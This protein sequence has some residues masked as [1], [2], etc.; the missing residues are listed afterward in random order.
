MSRWNRISGICLLVALATPATCADDT[1][2]TNDVQLDQQALYSQFERTLSNA[3]LT[4]KFTISG[5]EAAEPKSEKYTI[6]RVTKLK[7]GHFWLFEAKLEYGDKDLTLPL[8]LEVKW[9]GDT[10]MITLTQLPIPSLGTFSARVL[11]YDDMYAGTWRHGDVSGH[12][13][14]NIVR[15]EK[16]T[17]ENPHP[18]IP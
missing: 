2:A 8:A 4:G 13:Y 10:P 12:M 9:A 18:S 1:P 6:R 15:E 14:G 5:H 16:N 7:Q 17:T 3:I 11:I